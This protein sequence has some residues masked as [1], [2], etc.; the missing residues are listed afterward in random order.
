MKRAFTLIELLVV[1]AIIAILAAILFPVF[2]QAKAAA[3]KTASLSNSKQL[4]LASIMYA[5]DQDDTFCAQG[6]PN[7]GNNWGWQMT[8]VMHTIPYMKNYDILRDQSDS[9]KGPDWSGPMYS[10]VANGVL[11]GACGEATW[12]WKFQGVINASRD[13]FDSAPRSGS[14]VGL[15]AESIMFAQRFKMHPNSWMYAEGIRGAF[16]PWATVLMGPDGV[17]AE[18]SL[19]GQKNGQW[20]APVGDYNG[21]IADVYSGTSNFAF[22]DGHAKSMRPTQTV[23]IAKGVASNNAGGCANSGF[24]KM[25]DATRTQ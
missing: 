13:W 3:K 25:W 12:S 7:A 20:S 15:P 23:D 18:R 4:G 21:V 6:Q 8:W 11:A 9:H 5:G 24:L 22:A 17:D 16:D 10:F 19:P 1:I 14:S 2:A